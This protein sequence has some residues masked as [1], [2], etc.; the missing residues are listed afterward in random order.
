MADDKSIQNKA[1]QGASQGGAPNGE[2]QPSIDQAT[3]L[4]TIT[5]E[6]VEALKAENDA[7]KSDLDARHQEIE[8]LKAKGD[9]ATKT[10]KSQVF[11]VSK[12]YAGIARGAIVESTDKS[13]IAHMVKQGYWKAK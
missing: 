10:S 5:Q 4:L 3:G 8:A 6:E 12:E 9:V 13:E 1:E 11:T 2:T 7:L